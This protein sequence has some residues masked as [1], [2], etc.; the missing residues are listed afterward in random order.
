MFKKITRT[1]NAISNTGVSHEHSYEDIKRIRI[2]NQSTIIGLINTLIYAIILVSLYV[3]KLAK[4]EVDF[5]FIFDVSFLFTLAIFGFLTFWLM[6]KYDYRVSGIFMLIAFP[7]LLLTLSIVLD[8]VGIEYYYFP[9]FIILFYLL[10]NRR[11]LTLISIYYIIL[12]GLAKYFDDYLNLV[13]IISDKTHVFYYV[14][15]AV[16]FLSSYAFLRLFIT[17]YEKKQQEVETKNILLEKAVTIANQ[18]S[19]EIQLLLKELSHRTKNNLQLVSS[20]INIQSGKINDQM[21]KNTI[22]DIRNRIF[23]MSLLHQKLYINDNLNTFSLNGYTEDLI[24]YL[25]DIFDEKSNELR[26]IKDIESIDMKI[27][28]AV[29]I[30]LIIN[31]ILTNSFK[32]ALFGCKDKFIKISVKKSP[33]NGIRIAISDCGDGVTRLAED[34]YARSFGA[35]LIASFVKQLEGEISF[36]ENEKNEI[37]IRLK[38]IL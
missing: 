29:H 26:I 27:D 13:I 15:V 23:S 8:K 30:G 2:I 9:F 35:S 22:E 5:A 11:G 19:K 21:A 6:K 10:R 18:K 16:A 3:P 7:T 17:E 32:H 25:I 12:F 20:I 4:L 34:N 38:N 28:N 14:N 24:N 36:N 31:E 37:V 1:W 33:D